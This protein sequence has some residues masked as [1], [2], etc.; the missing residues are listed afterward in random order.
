MQ[1]RTNKAPLD[2]RSKKIQKAEP[3]KNF[4][5]L[6]KDKTK[7]KNKLFEDVEYSQL[8]SIYLEKKSLEGISVVKE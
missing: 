1:K 6:V 3:P 5:E 7:N 2:S 4:N 8:I